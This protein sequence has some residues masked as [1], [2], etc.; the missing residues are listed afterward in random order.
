M[1]KLSPINR[2][3]YAN[4]A[5]GTGHSLFVLIY[6][7]FGESPSRRVFPTL[8][9]DALHRCVNRDYHPLVDH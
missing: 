2:E 5:N 9:E 6:L 1:Y 8:D 7:S 3:S 4:L